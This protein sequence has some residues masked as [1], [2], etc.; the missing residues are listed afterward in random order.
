MTRVD[1][2]RGD[3]TSGWLNASRYYPASS[4]YEIDRGDGSRS[5]TD[6]WSALERRE[7]DRQPG[8]EPPFNKESKRYVAHQH[9]RQI[10]QRMNIPVT[11]KSDQK[12]VSRMR[13][14][15]LPTGVPHSWVRSIVS[16]LT[17]ERELSPFRLRSEATGD[18]SC[19][20]V[21]R[22]ESCHHPD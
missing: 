7:Y 2:K 12:R 3:D 10:A 14:K 6:A 20:I 15:A 5:F 19:G 11:S 8:D 13:H 22:N 17:A 1:V 21:K 4:R 18:Y 16:S 9:S